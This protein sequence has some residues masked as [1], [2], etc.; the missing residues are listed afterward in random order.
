VPDSFLLKA[1]CTA[2]TINPKVTMPNTP[3]PKAV[4][5]VTRVRTATEM[6]AAAWLVPVTGV[7]AKD[8]AI[9]LVSQYIMVVITPA[10]AAP[11]KQRMGVGRGG[12]EVD[13]G[14]VER[15]QRLD[16]ILR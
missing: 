9:L 3:V 5:P 16:L 10:I 12:F 11:L 13:S 15:E 4:I 6:L 8:R 1:T 14:M 2:N 7:W